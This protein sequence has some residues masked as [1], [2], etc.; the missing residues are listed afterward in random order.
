MILNLNRRQI[1]RQIQALSLAIDYQETTIDSWRNGL[2][3]WHG[4]IES[5]FSN[6]PEARKDIAKWW[7]DIKAFK[8]L[9]ETL[10]EKIMKKEKT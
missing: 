7:C 8:R 1:R 4:K 5:C 6:D 9:R 10:K 2:R 3:M